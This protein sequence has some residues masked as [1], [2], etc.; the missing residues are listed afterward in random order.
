MPNSPA[1]SSASYS[2]CCLASRAWV[3]RPSSAPAL[4]RDFALKLMDK[5]VYMSPSATLHSLSSIVHTEEDIA[6]TAKAI[7][8]ALDE[9]P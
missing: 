8:E 4:F 9:L 1:A 5:G 2:P 3:R 6:I 7:G